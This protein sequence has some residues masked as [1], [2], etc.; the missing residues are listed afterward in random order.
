MRRSAFL[1][2]L[3][4]C[5][6]YGENNDTTAPPADAG[7][8]A[9]TDAQPGTDGGSNSEGGP[10]CKGDHGPAPVDVGT[11]CVDSTEVTGRQYLE[12]LAAK[13]GDTSGQPVD[14]S[15]NTTFEPAAD[16]DPNEYPVAFVD[17]CDALAYCTW[18]GKRLCGKIG[19]GPLPK[20]SIP[21]VRPT[22]PGLART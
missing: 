16:I 22:T 20:A 2:A 8:E 13:A 18:A 5:G 21:A 1:V 9:G 6:T 4:C 14:C 7:T 17:W 19:G 15:W 12:F 3:A 10:S 11:Y